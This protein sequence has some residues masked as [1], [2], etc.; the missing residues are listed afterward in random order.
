MTTR[1]TFTEFIKQHICNTGE[2]KHFPDNRTIGNLSLELHAGI[3]YQ[4]TDLISVAVIQ[5]LT[6]TDALMKVRLW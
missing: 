5:Y 6:C 3:E 1:L 2:Y 4:L